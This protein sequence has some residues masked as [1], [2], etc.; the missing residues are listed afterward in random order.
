MKIILVLVREN[1]PKRFSHPAYSCSHSVLFTLLT[2]PRKAAEPSDIN[3]RCT[4]SPLC[5]RPRFCCCLFSAMNLEEL[6]N[7]I[8]NNVFLSNG[9]MLV[10]VATRK[11]NCWQH[12]KMCNLRAAQLFANNTKY[13]I[14]DGFSCSTS[15][16]GPLVVIV[17]ICFVYSDNKLK[18]QKIHGN[19]K[20]ILIRVAV[21]TDFGQFGQH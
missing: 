13:L 14:Q 3:E 12:R 17:W 2:T 8:C 10:G 7:S 9:W 18:N 15:M 5:Q 1:S 11:H 6:Q 20:L 4:A 21:N 16:R 19:S